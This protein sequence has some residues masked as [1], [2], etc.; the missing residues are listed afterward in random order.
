MQVL[1]LPASAVRRRRVVLFLLLDLLTW[2]LVIF[3]LFCASYGD[4]VSVSLLLGLGFDNVVTCMLHAV[5]LAVAVVPFLLGSS[6]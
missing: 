6:M 3:W 2:F 1:L 4:A 5:W